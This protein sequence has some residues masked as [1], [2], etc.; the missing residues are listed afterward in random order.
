[1]IGI[2]TYRPL[3]AQEP[4]VCEAQ[5][6]MTITGTSRSALIQLEIDPNTFEVVMTTLRE[7]LGASVNAI[8]Y[9]KT[10]NLIY[11][12]DPDR[13]ELLRIGSDAVV[14]IVSRFGRRLGVNYLG[15]DITFDGRYLYVV[16]S[17]DEFTETGE[18]K[19][20]DDHMLRFDLTSPNYSFDQID[21]KGPQT[22]MLDIAFDPLEGT[23]YGIDSEG[24]RL[25]IINPQTGEI[26]TPFEPTPLI[27]NAGSLFF[28]TFGNLFSYG[29]ELGSL[30]KTL[31]SI[32]KN[33]GGS[34]N[35]DRWKR[36]IFDRWLLLS[37]YN[38][39]RKEGISEKDFS[40]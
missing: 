8:G 36:S 32:D 11:G 30:Q 3:S 24:E 40:L 5:F 9:R 12:I 31:Y 21:L 7:D 22:L 26:L 29:T 34:N 2:L 20:L 33:T 10:D 16:G 17:L 19:R 38:R 4:F 6:F 27:D 35:I 39:Y 14:E 1:M 23:L 25:V 37:V 15:G 28:D 13:Y 18:L